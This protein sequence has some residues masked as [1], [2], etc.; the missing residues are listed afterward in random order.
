MTAAPTRLRRLGRRELL[1]LLSL[2]MA[3]TALSIDL[4][5]PAFGEIRASFDMAEDSSAAGAS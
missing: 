1:A 4:M 3:L 5:L 2:T